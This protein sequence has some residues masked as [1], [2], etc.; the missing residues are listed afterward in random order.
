MSIN[1]RVKFNYPLIITSRAINLRQQD[2]GWTMCARRSDE[3]LMRVQ[4]VRDN[5]M[6]SRW[7]VGLR[8]TQ[9]VPGSL[10]LY[11]GSA[12]HPE[13]IRIHGPIDWNALAPHKVSPVK[14]KE[15]ELL[16]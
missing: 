8:I 13:S 9:E 1:F 7:D 5:A 6:S 15:D 10:G 3:V 14:M 16:A 4:R 2:I 11:W 12:G